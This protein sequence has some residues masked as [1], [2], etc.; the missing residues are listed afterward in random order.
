[1]TYDLLIVGE[2]DP[3]HLRTVLAA[4]ADLPAE[5]V[6]VSPPGVEERNWAASVLC[7]YE[8]AAGDVTWSLEID[9]KVAGPPVTTFA[10]ELAARL[11][12][13]VLHVA[14]PIPPGSYWLVRPDSSRTRARVEDYDA[15]LVIE[16]VADPVA[17]LPG[18]PVAAQ[19]EV[20]RYHRMPTPITDELRDSGEL[21]TALVSALGGWEALVTR[22]TTGWPP[23][24]WYP[25]DY[26]DDDLAA[27]DE[28]AA[29]PDRFTPALDRIDQV[30]RAATSEL[31]DSAGEPRWW[32]R[33][34]PDP[35]PW[36]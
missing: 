19:P 9:G 25:R 6:D 1:M 30:Y 21:P 8:P 34:V 4:L 22:M 23:D 18:V 15:S 7:T 2:L 33:R 11:G 24:G 5:D 13:L 31:P 26:F 17:E 20:I 16:A 3:A 27:R 32:R 28:L 29:L 12:V 10:E 14:Q 35:L 36:S